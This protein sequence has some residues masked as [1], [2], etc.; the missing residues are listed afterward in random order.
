METAKIEIFS[1]LVVQ[2]RPD[3]LNFSSHVLRP[4]EL[5]LLFGSYFTRFCLVYFLLQFVHSEY[6]V[7]SLVGEN[8][9]YFIPRKQELQP[10]FEARRSGG[11]AVRASTDPW[12]VA[13]QF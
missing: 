4:S 13:L 6:T 5:A 7:T 12:P 1:W 11:D 2:H 3:L 10:K 9:T 8:R